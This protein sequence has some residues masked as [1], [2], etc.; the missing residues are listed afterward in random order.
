MEALH[1][2]TCDKDVTSIWKIILII[3]IGLTA[4]TKFLAII[5]PT[6]LLQQTDQIIKVPMFYVIAGACLAEC[7][8]LVYI[9]FASKTIKI[10]WAVF[11]F[12]VTILSYRAVALAN[13]LTY[14]PCL[15][16]VTD[17][18]PWLGRHEGP[19]LT[20]IAVWLLLTSVIQLIPKGKPA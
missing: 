2:S 17:W 18:W 3:I 7:F 4:L 10:A 13:G 15:G 19:I 6:P 11:A 14:C 8:L 9:G 12:A 20:S 16:N 1:K 5:N